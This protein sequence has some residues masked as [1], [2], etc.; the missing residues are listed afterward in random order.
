MTREG[1]TPAKRRVIDWLK[2]SGAAT[3]AEIA[4]DLDLTTVA[5]RQ[6]LSALAD[7]DLV[8]DEPQ[9]GSRRGRPSS[10]WRLT[11]K[12]A[13]LFPDHHGELTVGLL[14]SMR[15]VFGEEGLQRIIAAR[16]GDQ[17]AEY[18]QL[19]PSASASMR[20]RVVALAS[21]RSREGYMAG[22]SP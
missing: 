9:R 10:I 14:R 15:E 13:P 2:V 20:A 12:A 19:L 17:T 5:V 1:L 11:S 6:H 4:A 3:V 21:Q 16:A 22:S 8:R 7:D 18:R